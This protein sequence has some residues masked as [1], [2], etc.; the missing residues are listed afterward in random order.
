MT[1]LFNKLGPSPSH[2]PLISMYTYGHFRTFVELLQNV[3]SHAYLSTL[4]QRSRAPLALAAAAAAIGSAHAFCILGVIG[5]DL[6]FQTLGVSA[7]GFRVKGLGLG[8][9]G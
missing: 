5:F 4:P 3:R 7:S 8:L 2:N 9:R 6:R 1:S